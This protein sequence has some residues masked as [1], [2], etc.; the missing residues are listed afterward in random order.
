ML[1]VRTYCAAFLRR[2]STY[3]SSVSDDHASNITYKERNDTNSNEQENQQTNSTFERV[4]RYAL[5]LSYHGANYLGIQYNAHGP[6]IE[7]EL[8]SAFVKA[9]IVTQYDS[10][11]PRFVLGYSRASRTD[12]GVS[13][14]RQTVALNTSNQINVDEINSYLPSD[15]RVLGFKKVIKSF[16]AQKWC[17]NR[18]YSYIM[19]SFAFCHWRKESNPRT[20]YRI[21][22]DTLTMA[23][24]IFK[25]FEG[26]H[27]F[28][29]YT[30]KRDI[31]DSRSVRSIVSASISEPILYDNIEM[32]ALHI[33]GRSFMLHQIRRIV[34]MIIA[35]MRGK[36]PFDFIHKSF[37]SPILPAPTAPSLGLML[38][39]QYFE[40][41]NRI[42]GHQNEPLIWDEYDEEVE[43][44]KNEVV[45]P[46]IVQLEQKENTMEDF[47]DDIRKHG[48]R[49]SEDSSKCIVIGDWEG[50][51]L[52]EEDKKIIAK[53]Q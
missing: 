29:N 41:Y 45:V 1:C 6:T 11:N 24:Q 19:P 34:G 17:D 20:S 21:D 5:L 44:F 37:N 23:N 46:R 28:H 22:A 35:L 13:A 25:E 26:S 31:W 42:H 50:L 33:K 9:G 39:K 2:S 14:L 10:K 53:Y 51:D 36:A 27:K 16:D 7:A 43:K 52:D 47:L 38:E 48:F 15:I 4:K 49:V 32:V 8:F 40:G 12:S 30:E 3:T 18:S